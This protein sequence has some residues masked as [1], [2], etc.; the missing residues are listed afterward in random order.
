MP[1][2]D[3]QGLKRTKLRHHAWI[4]S[5]AMNLPGVPVGMN[6]SAEHE[7]SLPKEAFSGC[8]SD[9][10]CFGALVT[11]PTGAGFCHSAILSLFSFT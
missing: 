4:R 9:R 8:L 7:K 11:F 10:Y 1:V 5:P 2:Q 3:T 6:G